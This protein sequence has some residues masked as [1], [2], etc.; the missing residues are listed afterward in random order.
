MQE[1]GYLAT[2]LRLRRI[3]RMID[4]HPANQRHSQGDGQFIHQSFFCPS[5]VFLRFSFVT[6]RVSR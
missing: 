2:R 5:F 3:F 6:L 1:E 4:L